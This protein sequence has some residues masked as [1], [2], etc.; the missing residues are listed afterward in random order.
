MPNFMLINSSNE[1]LKNENIQRLSM[2]KN[3][4][5]QSLGI[6]LMNEKLQNLEPK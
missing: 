3:V 1:L 6:H 5:R 2:T 4:T